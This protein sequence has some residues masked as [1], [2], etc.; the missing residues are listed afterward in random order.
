MLTVERN[1]EAQGVTPDYSAARAAFEGVL[2]LKPSA[3]TA[4]LVRGRIELCKGYA[5][6]F[7]LRGD[8]EQ[9]RQALDA[10]LRKRQDEMDKAAKRGV[11]EGRFDVRGTLERVDMQGESHPLYF[12][13]WAGEASAELVCTTGRFDLDDFVGSEIGIVGRE[14]RGV[15]RG[16]TAALTRPREIDIARIEII[17]A[18]KTTK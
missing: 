5:E 14:L 10:A 11:F 18:R 3:A 2:A 6:G 1:K 8:L 15:I 12:V 17:A 9:Q 16:T 7:V 13:R 4:D